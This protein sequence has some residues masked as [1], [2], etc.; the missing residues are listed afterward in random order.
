MHDKGHLLH[1]FEILDGHDPAGKN[2]VLPGGVYDGNVRMLQGNNMARAAHKYRDC[3]ILARETAVRKDLPYRSQ[4]VTS[5][6]R[7]N[8]GYELSGPKQLR[9]DAGTLVR[10]GRPVV[11]EKNHIGRVPEICGDSAAAARRQHDVVVP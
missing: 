10:T 8:G 1:Q 11:C 7:A 6:M 4:P 2:A 3:S 9:G 5:E